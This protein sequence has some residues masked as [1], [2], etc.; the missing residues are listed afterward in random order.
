MT[1]YDDGPSSKL[2]EPLNKAARETNA[3]RAAELRAKTARDSRDGAIYMC[4]AH[5]ATDASVAERTGLSRET[6]VEL[7]H[8]W[9]NA[10]AVPW[11]PEMPPWPQRVGLPRIH[12]EL[13]R[14]GW[15]V[16]PDEERLRVLDGDGNVVAVILPGNDAGD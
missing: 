10:N 12:F 6:V 7:A 3:A 13:E 4:L 5:G 14:T 15:R 1:T 11:P 16:E 2:H 8:E 9:A